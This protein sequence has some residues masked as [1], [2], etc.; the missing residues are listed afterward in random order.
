[1]SISKNC[2][3]RIYWVLNGSVNH[4]HLAHL[5]PYHFQTMHQKDVYGI[6]ANHGLSQDL[7]TV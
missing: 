6:V 3:N 4:R 5:H 7:E 1:M 2:H